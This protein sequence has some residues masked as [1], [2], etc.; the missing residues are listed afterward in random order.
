MTLYKTMNPVGTDGSND[1]RDLS[2][3]CSVLDM[4]L[5]G[6]AEIVAS[7]LGISLPSYQKLIKN[8]QESGGALGFDNYTSLIAFTP[9]TSNVL[10]MD[11]STGDYY[12]WNGSSWIESTTNVNAIIAKQAAS[13]SSR[14]ANVLLASD[15]TATGQRWDATTKALIADTDVR[16]SAAIQVYK[17]DCYRINNISLANTYYENAILLDA[18]KAFVSLLCATQSF[19]TP[20]RDNYNLATPEDLAAGFFIAPADGYVVFQYSASNYVGRSFA[21][22]A[23]QISWDEMCRTWTLERTQA[24]VLR[25]FKNMAYSPQYA[26]VKSSL[27]SSTQSVGKVL[28]YYADQDTSVTAPI[29]VKAGQYV[30]YSA[31]LYSARKPLTFTDTSDLYLYSTRGNN[32]IIGSNM[33]AAATRHH[34]VANIPV[35]QDGFVRMD[36]CVYGG[37]LTFIVVTDAPLQLN[38]SY[39]NDNAALEPIIGAGYYTGTNTTDTVSTHYNYNTKGNAAIS[40]QN[41]G[42]NRSSLGLVNATAKPVMV[43]R[44]QIVVYSGKFQTPLLGFAGKLFGTWD[45]GSTDTS[46]IPVSNTLVSPRVVTPEQYS[47]WRAN[48]LPTTVPNTMNAGEAHFYAE[49]GDYALFLQGYVDSHGNYVFGRLRVF[50]SIEDYRRYRDNTFIPNLKWG[51]GLVNNNTYSLQ[52]NQL[53]LDS[54]LMFTDEIAQVPK[55]GTWFQSKLNGINPAE[56]YQLFGSS[57]NINSQFGA[58][59]TSATA[60][61]KPT[62]GQ[63]FYYMAGIVNETCYVAGSCAMNYE[64]TDSTGAVTS[65][66]LL[67]FNNLLAKYPPRVV[68]RD[69]VG[70]NSL[71]A[72]LPTYASITVNNPNKYVMQMTGTTD[73]NTIA[74]PVAKGRFYHGRYNVAWAGSGI[75]IFFSI[76]DGTAVELPPVV[77]TGAVQSQSGITYQ[78]GEIYFKAPSNGY[79]LL[80]RVNT[81]TGS[82][83]SDTYTATRFADAMTLDCVQITEDEYN[84]KGLA[85][86]R[87]LLTIPAQQ[88][89][90]LNVLGYLPVDTTK[91][92]KTEVTIQILEGESLLGVVNA[93]MGISGVGT[94]SDPKKGYN[95]KLTN[96]KGKKLKM[97]VG[98]FNAS[99]KWGLKAYYL[100]G[101]NT[102]DTGSN[103]LYRAMRQTRDPFIGPKSY[104]TKGVP[105]TVEPNWFDRPFSTEGHP[106]ELY[107]GGEF[108]GLYVLRTRA[109]APDYLM[110]DSN[111]TQI[112]ITPDYGLH[113][114]YVSWAKFDQTY[115]SMSNPELDDYTEGDATVSDA[116]TQSSITRFGKFFTDLAAGNISLTDDLISQYL[117]REAVVDFFVFSQLTGNKDGIRNNMTVATWDGNIWGFYPYDLDRTA[118]FN[119]GTSALPATDNTI[120]QDDALN[121]LIAYLQADITAR[122]KALRTSGFFTASKITSFYAEVANKISPAAYDLE[123]SYWKVNTLSFQNMGYIYNWYVSRLAWMDSQWK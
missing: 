90:R 66:T 75:P 96:A 34:V 42:S 123:T 11:T 84:L 36:N 72:L 104:L 22:S 110:E 67:K 116:T 57:L 78:S 58:P 8:L 27:N 95:I 5:N 106:V 52:Y 20:L 44:G 1:P 4:L 17:G 109:E 118:G 55:V 21:F 39:V 73:T 79:V 40:I 26:N 24:Q 102:R 53:A 111:S 9:D 108:F 63:G 43:R 54:F 98:S 120:S 59:L 70:V 31:S 86:T 35:V 12:F 46:Q 29:A 87:K 113:N 41:N 89:L 50:E 99:N 91:T 33:S 81:L 23:Q 65:R 85:T 15:F 25:T 30:H 3:N 68:K 97:K 19:Y 122:Y 38:L 94:V 83:A 14:V 88:G 16:Q 117:D 114:S 45:S 105:S 77:N 7:R 10:A 76:D 64:T 51:S 92:I 82:I 60:Y 47:T 101:T 71:Y 103:A 80:P 49:D 56:P 13:A 6:D 112:R 107:V 74:V 61:D 48:G 2:D 121:K 37:N 100:E 69:H 62:D 115:W 32:D 28:T 93:E 119:W 18:D